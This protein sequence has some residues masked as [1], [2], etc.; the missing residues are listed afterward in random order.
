MARSVNDAVLDAALNYIAD[1]GTTLHVCAGQPTSITTGTLAGATELAEFTL[2]VG[3]GNG[4]YTLANGDVS[5]RKLTVAAQTG[6]SI[7]ASG[8]ADH[9]AITDGT[10]SLIY[11][12]TVTSQAITSGGTVDT[13]AWDIEIEDPTAP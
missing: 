8:T 4:D 13:S 6:A 10:S 7:T 9:L 11:V 3:A 2:T 5:G 1:N 12:T